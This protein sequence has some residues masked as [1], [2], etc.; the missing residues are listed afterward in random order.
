MEY[1][2]IAFASPVRRIFDFL[3]H[4]QKRLEI[5]AHPGSRFFVR[6][7]VYGSTTRALAEEW[8]YAPLLRA[9][10]LGAARVRAIQS[11]SANL[12]LIYVL[13][14]LIVLLVLA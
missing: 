9:L 13:G 4:P 7:M 1:T 11:G 8:L 3:Y 2:A 14:A 12:Y 10:R 5:E 6:R